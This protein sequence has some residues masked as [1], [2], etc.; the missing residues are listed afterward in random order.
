MDGYGW[1]PR[2]FLFLQG[3]ASPFFA[4][5]GKALAERG[6]VVRRINF[7][8]GDRLFWPMQGAADFRGR[9]DDWPAFLAERLATWNITDIV[10]FGDCRPLHLTARR[11]ARALDLP[12]HV[13]E[14]GYLRPNWITLETGG[15]N[16]HSSLPRDPVWFRNAAYGAPAWSG[17][18][19]VESVFWR[20]A[21]GDVLYS[22]A[23]AAMSWR[24]PSYRSHRPWNAFVEYAGWGRKLLRQRA[25]KRSGEWEIEALI[26][27][28]RPYFVLP[29]QLDS[30]TQL[31][32]HSPFGG[33]Q[34]PLECALASFAAHAP[35]EATLVVREHPLDNGLRDWSA[36]SRDLAASHGISERVLYMPRGELTPLLANARGLVTVNSTVGVLALATGVPVIA[37]G[38]AI[39]DL[40]E[41]TFQHGLDAFWTGAT[42]PDAETFDAFRRVVAHRTQL[43]GGF[44]SAE[45]IRLAINAAVRRLEGAPASPVPPKPERPEAGRDWIDQPISHPAPELHQ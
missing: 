37:L 13:L 20:R 23:C 19:P 9:D 16:G 18:T 38:S 35:R 40:P 17:G 26:A 10:L 14:E 24:Y 41:L 11:I 1:S 7:N 15:V 39:Y 31:R 25:Q 45:G 2:R 43:N 32:L 33:M 36:L 44:F 22:S 6:H 5:L 30:D 34:K 42:P 28:G 21:L 3:L 12:V 27:S 4:R 8:G 29:L